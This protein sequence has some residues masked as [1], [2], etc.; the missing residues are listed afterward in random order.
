MLKALVFLVLRKFLVCLNQ[1]ILA[2]NCIYQVGFITCFDG[3]YFQ[4]TLLHFGPLFLQN[5]LQIL[6]LSHLIPHLSLKLSHCEAHTI[7]CKILYKY[8]N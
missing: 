3:K 7:S 1:T 2:A 4:L 5:N 6:K 8:L